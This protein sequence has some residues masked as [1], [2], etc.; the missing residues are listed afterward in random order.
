MTNAS[1]S[2][3]FMASVAIKYSLVGIA[4]NNTFFFLLVYPPSASISVTPW[5][6]VLIIKFLIAFSSVVIISN[7]LYSDIPN[8]TLSLIIPD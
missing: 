4:H 5:F 3:F 7:V 1:G 8:I 6:N 2:S